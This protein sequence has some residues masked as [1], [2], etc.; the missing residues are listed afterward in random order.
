MNLV[1][2][3]LLSLAMQ[4]AEDVIVLVDGLS[5]SEFRRSRLTRAEV[6]HRLASMATALSGLPPDVTA[7]APEIDWDG[8]RS[9]RRALEAGGGDD[10]SAVDAA[11]FGATALAPATLSWLRVYRQQQP[12]W[13]AFRPS[14]DP[15]PAGSPR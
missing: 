8:W 14:Q 4:T 13:F 5:E 12:A 7:A 3:P 15:P 9:L 1:T 10:A 11:W 2:A 6:R